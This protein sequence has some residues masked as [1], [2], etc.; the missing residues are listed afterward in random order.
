[1]FCFPDSMFTFPNPP[2][3]KPKDIK[4]H[5]MCHP[6]SFFY[7]L[8]TMNYKCFL[9]HN[10]QAL[11]NKKRY[12]QSLRRPEKRSETNPTPPAPLPRTTRQP[13]DRELHVY[14]LWFVCRMVGLCS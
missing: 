3:K 4:V 6:F 14:V 7:H 5:S 13:N 12:Y 2:Q 9:V 11:M 10:I 8:R 1:M